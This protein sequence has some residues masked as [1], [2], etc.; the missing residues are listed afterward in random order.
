M[1]NILNV[2]L[3]F[4]LIVFVFTVAGMDLFGDYYI[5]KPGYR[6]DVHFQTFYSGMMVLF[7][8]STGESWNDIMHTYETETC[9]ITMVKIYWLTYILICFFIYIN[10]LI[11]VIFYEFE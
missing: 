2:L 6:E 7:R 11:A 3:L 9:K 4:A 8:A 5:D 10:V 1:H